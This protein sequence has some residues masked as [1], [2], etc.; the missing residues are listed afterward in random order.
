MSSTHGMTKS[1]E[2]ITWRGMHDRCRHKGHYGYKY[3]GGKGVKVCERWNRF[4]NF[5]A[6][7]GRRPKGS[8]LDRKKNG[9]GYRKSNCRWATPT[10]QRLNRHD[11]HWVVVEGKRM[12]LTEACKKLGKVYSTI[13]SRIYK[14]GK[15]P[16][17]AIAA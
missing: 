15:T 1:P 8:W 9:L 16:Q 5:L 13:H 14:A 2:Y 11:V 7:M 17:E 3:Y 4:E 6:D 12:N 10:E